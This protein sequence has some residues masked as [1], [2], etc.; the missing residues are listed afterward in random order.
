MITVVVIHHLIDVKISN[1][2]DTQ[3]TKQN[4]AITAFKTS[5]AGAQ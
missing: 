2:S 3:A 1:W 5:K 4:T